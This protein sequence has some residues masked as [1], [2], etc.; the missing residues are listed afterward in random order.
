MVALRK[1]VLVWVLLASGWSAGEKPK[2]S[3]KAEAQRA[4]VEAVLRQP[5]RS[6]RQD[7][8]AEHADDL[9]PLGK[10]AVPLL[11]TFLEDRALGY[12]AALTMMAI[13]EDQALPLLF[14]S[15]PRG[16]VNTSRRAFERATR[17][18]EAGQP[19]PFKAEMRA[20]ALRCLEADPASPSEEMLQALGVSG[21][22]RDLP[23][24][25]KF[26]A[27]KHGVG[28]H[29]MQIRHAALASLVRLGSAPHLQLVIGEL[30]APVPNPMTLETGLSLHDLLGRVPFASNPRLLP[31]LCKHLSD[32]SLRMGDT[33]VS[34]AQTAA[35]SLAR[36]LQKKPSGGSIPEAKGLCASDVR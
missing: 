35:D 1:H 17:R 30:E 32:P 21:D 13:D 2:V 20:A 31:L 4:Q 15:I 23:L 19:G 24:L 12:Q 36:I 9:K 8:Q 16:D 33:G 6:Y 11:A 34:T 22:Q 27:F 18:L 10:A 25:E 7:P 28:A 5:R 26:T 29:Q 3:S 14:A